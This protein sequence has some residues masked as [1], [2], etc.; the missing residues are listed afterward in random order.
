MAP[1]KSAQMV[2]QGGDRDFRVTL[3]SGYSFDM[4]PGLPTGGSPMEFL[5][6]AA[7]GCTAMDVISIL[8]KKRM[9]VTGLELEINGVQA[10]TPPNVYT[11]ATITYVVHGEVD[12]EAVERA[13]ELSQTKYCSASIM[14]KRAGMTLHTHYRIEP[15]VAAPVA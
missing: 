1:I 13:I 7:A 12:A 6:A 5:L 4:A 3:G 2:W 11:E 10:P 9:N 15:A 8:Q 14:L